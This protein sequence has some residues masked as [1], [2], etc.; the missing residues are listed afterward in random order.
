[1]REGIG[2]GKKTVCIIIEKLRG[3]IMHILIA[4]IDAIVLR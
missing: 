1:M 3:F 2:N 4:T